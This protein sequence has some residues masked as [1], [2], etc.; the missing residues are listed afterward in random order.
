MTV[1]D[2][3]NPY[4]AI[5]QLEKKFSDLSRYITVEEGKVQIKI[6]DLYGN[7][8]SLTVLADQ[9][10]S[11]VES[12]EGDISSIS[13]LADQIE[14]RVQS[15]EGN[16]STL[17]QRANGIDV[18]IVTIN[19][20]ISDLDDDIDSE[21]AS[22]ETLI[23]AYGQGVLTA[24]KGK[25][26]GVL[27][28]AS[29]SVDIV[30]MPANWSSPSIDWTL[31]QFD[32]NG[33]FLS[34]PDSVYDSALETY[35][36]GKYSHWWTGATYYGIQSG[37]GSNPLRITSRDDLVL[38]AEYGG[39]VVI[40][41][42]ARFNS[43][44]TTYG[45]LQVKNAGG[46]DVSLASVTWV[47]GKFDN[48]SIPNKT[49]DIRKTDS[50]GNGNGIDFSNASSGTGRGATIAYVQDRTGGSDRRIKEDIAE[51]DITDFKEFYEG[52]QP[53]QF[54]FKKNIFD[55]EDPD[56]IRYGFIAQD[57]ESL[58]EK[59]GI[60]EGIVADVEV[61]K[62]TPH[63]KLVDGKTKNVDY[64]SFHALHVLY[65]RHLE[66]RIAELERRLA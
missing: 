52:L 54:K 14:S 26:R 46:N 62:G 63:A 9:I 19:S 21:V 32:A 35:T 10:E 7:L 38:D 34:V 50:A 16:I 57:I 45:N 51:I 33:M 17:T 4:S 8:G 2:R 36:Y 18:N 48:L 15:A 31:A 41:G 55:D 61:P 65:A 1:L 13:E 39:Y 30:A 59:C 23:R 66:K 58:A 5:P 25:T 40:Q 6:E 42:T 12:A 53:S 49:G 47:Q 24:Y 56:R 22:R 20:N 29:G 3:R 27:V 43:T 44:W 64:N 11:R 37:N 28:N 60:G